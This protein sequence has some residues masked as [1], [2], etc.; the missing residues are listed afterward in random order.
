MKRYYTIVFFLL[1]GLSVSAQETEVY[2]GLGGMYSSFQDT[3]FT[4]VQFN[5]LTVIPE[6]GFSIISDKNYWH[7]NAYGYAFNEQ[8][9]NEDTITYSRLGYNVRFGYLRE[10]EPSFY[11]GVN[12]DIVDYYKRFTGLLGNGA[13]SYKLSSDIYVSGKYLWN[14][15][16]NWRIRFGLDYG[17][18]TFVNTEPSFGANFQQNIIDNGLVTFIDDD[19][20]RPWKLK[21]MAFKGF[22]EQFNIRTSFHV[23]YRRR[24]SL[25]YSWDLRRFADNKGYPVTDARH[26]M[27][28]IFNLVNHQ[29]K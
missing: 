26:Q 25:K 6:L 8:F 12:W 4:D 14:L 23:D 28:L 20:K 5:K 10:L 24:L 19:T 3:R 11:M 15:D 2:L 13:D 1:F 16:D 21:N 7:M 27:T 9:P 29:K 22:W 18:F 17:L